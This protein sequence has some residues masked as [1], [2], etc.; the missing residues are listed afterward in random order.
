MIEEKVQR[1]TEA[2]WSDST[3]KLR[4]GSDLFKFCFVW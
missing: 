2:N 4:I 3:T 1:L